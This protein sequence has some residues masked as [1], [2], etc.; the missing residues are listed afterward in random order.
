MRNLAGL[1]LDVILRRDDDHKLVGV[2]QAPDVEQ[3]D[4]QAAKGHR[5]EQQQQ[6]SRHDDA[7]PA[8]E[9]IGLQHQEDERNE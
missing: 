4:A 6:Q 9:K 2:S 8:A 3:H 7:E 1:R 5:T